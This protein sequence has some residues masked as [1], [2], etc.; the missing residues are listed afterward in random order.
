MDIIVVL[1]TSTDALGNVCRW[2]DPNE[3]LHALFSA[4]ARLSYSGWWLTIP[5]S[6]NDIL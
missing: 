1:L 4:D 5:I 6:R 3:E 2:V